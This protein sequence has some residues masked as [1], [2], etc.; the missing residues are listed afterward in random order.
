MSEICRDENW[1]IL[2][3]AER[4]WTRDVKIGRVN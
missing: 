4:F 3:F 2:G 1:D